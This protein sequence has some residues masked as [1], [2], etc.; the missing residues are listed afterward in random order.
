MLERTWGENGGGGGGG[1]MQEKKKLTQSSHHSDLHHDVQ[2]WYKTQTEHARTH[3]H[4]HERTHTS[5]AHGTIENNETGETTKHE[6]TALPQ[7]KEGRRKKGQRQNN[8]HLDLFALRRLRPRGDLK[9]FR[10]ALPEDPDD[11]KEAD[12]EA[13][14]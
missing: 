9:S 4:T 8:T 14:E 6:T 7:T 1:T 10:L 12:D 11:T 5:H 3:T 2:A 13:I